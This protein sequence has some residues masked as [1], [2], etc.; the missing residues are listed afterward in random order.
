MLFALLRASVFFTLTLFFCIDLRV[1]IDEVFKEYIT[2]RSFTLHTNYLTNNFLIIAEPSL[3]K[4]LFLNLISN[5][6]DANREMFHVI[7]TE[8]NS[9]L[10]IQFITPD[11]KIPNNLQLF[12]IGSSTKGKGHG[13]GLFLCNKISDYLNLNLRYFQDNENIIFSIDFNRIQK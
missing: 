6:L 4:M 1:S 3:V 9:C 8:N 12:K 5:G 7:I 11:R 13:Y 10:T 2:A